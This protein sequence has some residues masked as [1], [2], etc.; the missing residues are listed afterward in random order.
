MRERERVWW[1]D[2][3]VRR[4]ESD[5]LFGFGLYVYRVCRIVQRKRGTS[6]VFSLFELFFP[7]SSFRDS[8]FPLLPPATHA[9]LERGEMYRK[10]SRRRGRARRSG[11][12]YI[13][14][15]VDFFSRFLSTYVQVSSASR[16][17]TYV[18]V[19]SA[20]RYIRLYHR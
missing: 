2:G 20:S 4:T 15:F 6:L 9:R 19:S 7:S 10:R 5:E 12:W 18:Q 11:N 16:Y 3:F 17:C 1:N 8:R 13:L 14:A